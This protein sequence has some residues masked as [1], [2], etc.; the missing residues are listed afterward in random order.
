MLRL[1]ALSFLVAEDL[2][3][4]LE[5]L[6]VGLGIAAQRQAEH[7]LDFAGKLLYDGSPSF[8]Q[9]VFFSPGW[10]VREWESS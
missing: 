10:G 8:H 1:L 4:E 9:H 6:V 2:H 7:Q 3:D 5:K